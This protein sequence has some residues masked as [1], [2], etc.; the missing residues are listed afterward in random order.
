MAATGFEKAMKVQLEELQGKLAEAHQKP[1]KELEARMMTVEHENQMLRRHLPRTLRHSITAGASGDP[2]GEVP[3]GFNGLPGATSA[4]APASPRRHTQPVVKPGAMVVGGALSWQP[5]P[6]TRSGASTQS[7]GVSFSVLDIWGRRPRMSNKVSMQSCDRMSTGTDSRG[8]SCSEDDKESD[9]KLADVKNITGLRRKAKRRLR[10]SVMSPT[11]ARRICWDIIGL[12][13]VAYDFVVIPLQILEQ[14][15]H[16]INVAMTWVIRLFWTFDIL[17]NFLTGYVSPQG[18]LEMRHSRVARQYMRTRFSFDGF[19]VTIDWLEAIITAINS[20]Q[21][22]SNVL[23]VLGILR[24]IRLMRLVRLAKTKKLSEFL[25]ERIRSEGVMIVAYIFVIMTFL[26]GL[27]HVIACIWHGIRTCDMDVPEGRLTE[28]YVEA[29]HYILSLFAG[30]QVLDPRNLLERIFTILVLI[31]AFVVSAAF[32]GSLTTA[33]TRLQVIASKRS[34]AFVSLNRFL[35][36]YGISR[37]LASRVQRNARHALREQNRY[38]PEGSVELMALIS[39]PLRVEIHY[40]VY[41]PVLMTHPFFHLYNMVNPVAV[42]NICHSAVDSM[43]I[44]RGDFV[45]A[46]SEPPVRP[47]MYFIVSG[48]LEYTPGAQDTERLLVQDLLPRQWVAEAVLWTRWVHMGSLQAPTECRLASLDAERF[49]A[50]MSTFPSQHGHR[51]AKKFVE[52]LN[53][54]S[55][56][57]KLTDLARNEGEVRNM[58]V[59]VFKE[60]DGRFQVPYAWRRRQSVRSIGSALSERRWSLHSTGSAMRS[61][62]PTTSSTTS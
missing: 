32:V 25:F 52:T 4:A 49:A 5:L 28:S 2:R 43:L 22:E 53:E 44:S 42:R 39:D 12:L 48:K 62:V 15:N 33:M 35:H 54:A 29:F 3:A 51:Y 18:V 20:G 6:S 57:G 31:F 19:L 50:I 47:R 46:E 56:S 24:G 14:P 40:E 11:A 1:L 13:L 34:K 60:L 26:V 27:I 36:D 21:E 55:L 7:D 9:T 23:K 61:I 58:T 16:P 17:V 30:E 41:S 59:G 10:Q 37:E 38:T 8:S 45:F